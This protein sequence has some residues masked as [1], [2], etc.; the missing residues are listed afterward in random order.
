M[1]CFASP[2]LGR[3]IDS[4]ITFGTLGNHNRDVG[5][6]IHLRTPI[7]LPLEGFIHGRK[8]N[9]ALIQLMAFTRCRASIASNSMPSLLRYLMS[10]KLC[11]KSSLS[12]IGVTASQQELVSLALSTELPGS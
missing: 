7:G 6:Y 10:V 1:P 9:P 12:M 2:T 8:S 4:G 3:H 5:R 11:F